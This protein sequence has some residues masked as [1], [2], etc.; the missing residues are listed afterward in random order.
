[1][2]LALVSNI[3]CIAA[4]FNVVKG[5]LSKARLFDITANLVLAIPVTTLVLSSI[6]PISD[7]KSL[8]PC[9]KN[10][11][12]IEFLSYIEGSLLKKWQISDIKSIS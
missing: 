11:G 12:Q 1:M 10:M 4:I 5:F 7:F 2:T 3:H 9:G 6:D 8:L